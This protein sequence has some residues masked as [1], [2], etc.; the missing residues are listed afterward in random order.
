MRREREFATTPSVPQRFYT[1]KL[2]HNFN[3]A[4]YSKYFNIIEK[5][6]YFNKIFYTRLHLRP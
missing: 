3:H 4:S 5:I 1:L 2:R 6:K